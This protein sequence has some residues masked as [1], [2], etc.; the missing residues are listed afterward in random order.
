MD[1]DRTQTTSDI[2]TFSDPSLNAANLIGFSVEA[3]DGGIGKIDEATG[4]VGSSQLIVDTGPGS[5]VRRS[6]C[7]RASSTASTSTRRPSSSTA[8]RTRS[9]TRRSSTTTS[10][11]TTRPIAA[12]SAGTTAASEPSVFGPG[13]RWGGLRPRSLLDALRHEAPDAPCPA[14]LRPSA[15]SA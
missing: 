6:C 4:D 14:S 12:A 1:R 3:T 10:F 2:W 7:R 8:R 15:R 13:V 5:S 9:K 11:A